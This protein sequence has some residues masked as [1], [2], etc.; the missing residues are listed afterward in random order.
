MV[1]KLS[2]LLEQVEYTLLQGTVNLDITTLI[3][4]SSEEANG[5]VFVCIRGN[6]SDGH[7]FAKQV[8]SRG[9]KAIIVEQ[10]IL[11]QGTAFDSTTVILVKDTRS[12]L[13]KMAAAY[14]DYP[15]NKLKTIGITGTK[16]KTTTAYMIKA[17]LEL[18]GIKTGLIGTI[19]VLI[20]DDRIDSY[21]T[22]PD[23]LLMQKYL[24]QM[25]KA[26]CESVVMEVS[27]QGLKHQ[28]V[29]GIQYDYGVFTNI[30]PD[31]I[32]AGEHS[33][34]EEYLECKS[35]L[36]QQCKLGIINV[37][38]AEYKKVIENHT[39]HLE[40]FGLQKGLMIYATNPYLVQKPGFL[41]IQFYV[42][43][44]IN[45][46]VELAIPGVFNIYNALAAIA[47][48]R[49][50]L[51][52]PDIIKEALLKVQVKGRLEH[53]PISNDF[54][55]IIDYAHN[56]VSL[57]NVLTTLR[58]YR[59]KRLVCLFGCGGDRSKIRR[60][61][62]GKVSS[63]LA[64]VS[65][66]TSDNPRTENMDDIMED[67]LVGVLQYEGK[68]IKIKDRRKAILYAVTQAKKGD[69]ILLAGK[70]HEIYQEINGIRYPMDERVILEDIVNQYFS[71]SSCGKE[72]P[73]I[74]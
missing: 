19:E 73:W 69:V 11:Q 43:G 50:F 23:A 64:D 22:T 41:G 36:F 8:I 59:P 24:Y 70:G 2:K 45:M 34:Y 9:A 68:Y 20:D 18:A 65:I 10:N 1:L 63:R 26:G 47:V 57:E 21:N 51:I 52:E 61:E 30:S 12:A 74:E 66:I 58:E 44:L 72:I 32:G 71:E 16:G 38:C 28:R 54:T 31:H 39:C 60:F 62:M 67:I 25:V 53:I 13:S 15:A 40:T 4:D 48:A 7:D 42:H 56:S 3:H 29:A 6:Q 14:Y 35:R 49:H 27:S 37:D 5:A 55:V 17:I 33:S 46:G